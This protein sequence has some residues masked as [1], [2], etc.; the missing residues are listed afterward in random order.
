M[1]HAIQ[2][3]ML[4]VLTAVSSAVGGPVQ[5]QFQ[6][7]GHVPGGGWSTH[8]GGM[9]A[10][11]GVIVG[12]TSGADNYRAFRWTQE[13]G[14][15][16]LGL[17]P[18]D[19]S[20]SWGTDISAD[21]SVIVGYCE[22]SGGDGAMAFRWTAGGGM[23][24]LGDLPGGDEFSDAT[25]VS[26][27]G[28]VV[29]GYGNGYYGETGYRWSAPN[30]MEDL[31]DLIGPPAQVIVPTRVSADGSVV[32]GN[33]S[34]GGGR[35][36]F[37]WA[38]GHAVEVLGDLPGGESSSLAYAISDDGAV[39][40]GMGTIERRGN[41]WAREAYRWTADEGLVPL[42]HLPGEAE[43]SAACDVSADGSVIVGTSDFDGWGRHAFIWDAERGMRDLHDVLTDDCGLDLAGWQLIDAMAISADGRVIAG[44]GINPDGNREAWRAVIPEP[45]V[46][47]ML[48][49]GVS[50]PAMRRRRRA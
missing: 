32:I 29:V 11:G 37:R 22:E 33:A 50:V 41:L 35:L 20:T 44:H 46:V 5:P 14:M 12:T 18:G 36:A 9:S 21:G 42:G 10:D 27:N 28:S 17:L 30:L 48:A 19:Y 16:S 1:G 47:A 38:A 13:G 26:A 40:V 23:V 15:V 6:G 3:S 4:V 43:Y 45:A 8:V 2:A 24:P 34:F 25:G 31:Q 39:V 7:L 49:I